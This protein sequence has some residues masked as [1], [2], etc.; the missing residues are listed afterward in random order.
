MSQER[1]TSIAEMELKSGSGLG[2]GKV[3][4]VRLLSNSLFDLN[5]FRESD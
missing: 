4:S 3:Q 1:K 2:S 5:L